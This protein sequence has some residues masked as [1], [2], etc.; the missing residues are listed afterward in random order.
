MNIHD[1]AAR[2]AGNPTAAGANP[3]SGL[4]TIV[5]EFRDSHETRQALE[6]VLGD[7]KKLLAESGVVVREIHTEK[8]RDREMDE[9]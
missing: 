5:V 2:V 3:K 4:V 9:E 1:I 7:A 6:K 8:L